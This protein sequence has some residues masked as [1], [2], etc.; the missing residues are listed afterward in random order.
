M[1][2]QETGITCTLRSP[3]PPSPGRPK[4]TA[5]NILSVPEGKKDAPLGRDTVEEGTLVQGQP[6]A[7]I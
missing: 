6:R 2:V 1:P 4:T 5:I 7:R 3:P